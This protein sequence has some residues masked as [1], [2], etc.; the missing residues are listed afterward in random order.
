MTCLN[1]NKHNQVTTV[2]YLLHNKFAKTGKLK[3]GFQ[4][5]STP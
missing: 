3:A 1:K 2:Y 4:V 5:E